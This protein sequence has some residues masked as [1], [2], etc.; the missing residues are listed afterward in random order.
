M[1]CIWP[2]SPIQRQ[3]Q[4]ERRQVL[5]RHVR[6]LLE[7]EEDDNDDETWDE[8]ITLSRKQNR[9]RQT[10]GSRPIYLKI[11]IVPDRRTSSCIIQGKDEGHRYNLENGN[12]CLCVMNVESAE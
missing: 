12:G 9:R 5:R 2:N 3:Q 8:I 7:A 4:D 10:L 1:N 6:F 11:H